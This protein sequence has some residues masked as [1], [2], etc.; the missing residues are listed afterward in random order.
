MNQVNR[1]SLA[2]VD[3]TNHPNRRLAAHL[4]RTASTVGIQNIPHLTGIVTTFFTSAIFPLVAA[5]AG[6]GLVRSRAGASRTTGDM[7]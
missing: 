1:D 5:L 2:A 6:A 3:I 4:A 7:R